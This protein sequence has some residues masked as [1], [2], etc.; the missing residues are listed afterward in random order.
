MKLFGC[1]FIALLF[2]ACSSEIKNDD[3]RVE[4]ETGTKVSELTIEEKEEIK[5]DEQC[6]GF[7]VGDFEPNFDEDDEVEDAFRFDTETQTRTN[8]I[9]IS[10][11]SL[12]EDKLFGHS[13]V[14]G[15]DRPFSGDVL[16]KVEENGQIISYSFVGREPGDHK[17]DGVF[18]FIVFP[19][20]NK[21]I[22]TWEANKKERVYKR[23][24]ELTRKEYKYDSLIML[25]KTNRFVNW[26]R[27]VEE[28]TQYEDDG[29]MEEWIEE[30]YASTTDK[31]F[32][33]N[34]SKKLLKKSEVENLTKGDLEIIRN[35]IYAR[36]GYSFKNK[37]YRNFFDY[38]DWYIPVHADITK[39]LTEI[40]KKNIQLLMRY[41]KN[42]KEYYD[43]FGR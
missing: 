27:S 30:K 11:D 40:E 6:I 39:S 37:I 33:T 41:E 1:L 13:V 43:Y 8:K 31:I 16:E 24:Y 32:K 19:K 42:A 3:I 23:K 25:D 5:R 18:E 21:M 4:E 38:Q 28:V 26:R 7:W 22:G 14:A 9:N 17:N 29:K 35:T 2:S 15:N 34:A 20:E 12:I 10:I 36:H